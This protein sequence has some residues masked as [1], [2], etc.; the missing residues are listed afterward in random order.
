MKTRY[1]LNRLKVGAG[2]TALIP[3][4]SHE[5]TELLAGT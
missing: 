5:D 4:W 3:P 1:A 2:D